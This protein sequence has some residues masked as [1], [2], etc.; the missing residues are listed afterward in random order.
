MKTKEYWDKDFETR[1]EKQ[2]NDP[3]RQPLKVIIVPHSHNDPGWLKTFVNYFLSDTRQILNLAV[4][5]MPEFT[6]MSFIWSEISFLNM[7][8]EQAHPSKQRALKRLIQEGRLEITTGGWVM[9]DE[10][11]VHMY[12][13][14]DQLIEGHQWV[15]TNL[16][17]IPK[18]GWSIG[19]KSDYLSTSL[20]I[21]CMNSKFQ[22]L[23]VMAVQFHICLLQAA[24]LGQSF[25]EF[26][27]VGNRRVRS[28]IYL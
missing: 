24:S 21:N 6:N 13:M 8:W 17:Y 16:N 18:S 28:L 2:M 15:K 7:W 14:L 22:I 26:T 9:T 1:Y 4:T 19:R 5:K 10:A 20:Q 27:T 11:N 3:H 12:A 23:S 25:K